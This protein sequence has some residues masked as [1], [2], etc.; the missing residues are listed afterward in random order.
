MSAATIIGVTAL[1]IVLTMAAAP[2]D[3]TLRD[4]SPIRLAHNGV[5]LH[6]PAGT[7]AVAIAKKTAEHLGAMRGGLGASTPVREAIL[8]QV[9]QDT[10]A[11]DRLCWVVSLD[12]TGWFHSHGPKGRPTLP[13]T[14]FIVYIDAQS[15]Q[16]LGSDAGNVS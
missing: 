3:P 11:M 15:G 2:A 12:P 8:A 10:P 6:S 14:F 13:A 5:H 9:V 1:A 16:W 7:P 4:V